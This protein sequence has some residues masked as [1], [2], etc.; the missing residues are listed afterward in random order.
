MDRYQDPP[1]VE[2]YKLA[3]EAPVFMQRA[4]FLC[5]RDYIGVAFYRGTT[6]WE[7]QTTVSHCSFYFR[8]G[9]SNYSIAIE[10]L[11][12]KYSTEISIYHIAP[13]LFTAEL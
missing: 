1:R 9:L 12:E 2:D 5:S 4:I 3:V 11:F 8:T 7:L 13:Y 6:S 10:M